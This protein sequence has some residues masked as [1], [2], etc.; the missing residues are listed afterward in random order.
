M[1]TSVGVFGSPTA[2]LNSGPI[3]S[4]S[5]FSIMEYSPSRQIASVGN[6]RYFGFYASAMEGLP[7]VT[8]EIAP[9]SNISWI[10]RGEELP[11]IEEAK[12][13]HLN[14]VL[15]VMK[16]FFDHQFH[17]R[18]DAEAAWNAFAATIA[19]YVQ[20]GTIVA[21]YPIDEPFGGKLTRSGLR[22]NQMRDQLELVGSMIKRTFPGV[23]IATILG[24]NQWDN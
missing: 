9:F 10:A 17:V 22:K 12:R 16:Y 19:P 14:V 18:S 2:P 21:F 8:A 20:D 1:T 4:V 6:I 7:D 24:G 23:A 15:D 3:S 11:K 5:V 13:Y